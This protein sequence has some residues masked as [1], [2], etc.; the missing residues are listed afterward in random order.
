[1]KAKLRRKK[2]NESALPRDYDPLSA[3]ISKTSFAKREFIDPFFC[4][5][6]N[7]MTNGGHY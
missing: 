1:M 5:S 6:Q 3:I 4:L 2:Q 7:D